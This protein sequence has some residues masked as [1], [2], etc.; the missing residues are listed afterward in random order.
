M[1]DALERCKGDTQKK[2]SIHRVRDDHLTPTPLLT[3]IPEYVQIVN[4]YI[5][6]QEFYTSLETRC[7][8]K[9]LL[10]CYKSHM[11]SKPEV[12]GLI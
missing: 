8:V 4:E 3:D 2:D 9:R 10:H 1:Q 5:T 12:A 11:P 6:F 7:S